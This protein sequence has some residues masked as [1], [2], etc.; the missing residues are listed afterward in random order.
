MLKPLQCLFPVLIIQNLKRRACPD[1]IPGKSLVSCY[2]PIEIQ[3]QSGLSNS[4]ESVAGSS[5]QKQ[6]GTLCIQKGR[7]LLDDLLQKRRS[8]RFFTDFQ[9]HLVER[10]A[11]M[12]GISV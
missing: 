6:R 3:G 4:L 2:L 11:D 7:R 9:D 5:Q 8:V 12:L 1:H 10:A